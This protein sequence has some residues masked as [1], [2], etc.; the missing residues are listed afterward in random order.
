LAGKPV[1]M[2][3]L[4]LIYEFTKHFTLKKT[5]MTKKKKNED[6]GSVFSTRVSLFVMYMY[7]NI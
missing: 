4:Y 3:I 6:E 2:N 7:I 1:I 5:I